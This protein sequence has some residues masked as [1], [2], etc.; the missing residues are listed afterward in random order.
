MIS[1]CPWHSGWG[2]GGGGGGGG[3]ERTSDWH[4]GSGAAGS[5]EDKWEQREARS[6]KVSPGSELG[7]RHYT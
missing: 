2:A 5:A 3:A 1:H 6:V 4:Y 7:Q